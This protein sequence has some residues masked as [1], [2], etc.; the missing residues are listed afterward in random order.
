MLSFYSDTLL[1][2]VN[3]LN[4]NKLTTSE[5][6]GKLLDNVTISYGM[7]MASG[8]TIILFQALYFM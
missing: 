6:I 1:P 4:D 7:F 8:L 3:Q 5:A 2:P